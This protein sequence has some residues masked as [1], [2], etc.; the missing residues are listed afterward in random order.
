[1]LADAFLDSFPSELMPPPSSVAFPDGA[2]FRIK[3]PSIEG[4]KIVAAVVKEAEHYG[5]TINR[6]SQGSGAMLHTE[7][8]LREM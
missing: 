3:I 2:N 6:V 8:E 4:P 1:M 5:I 7:V